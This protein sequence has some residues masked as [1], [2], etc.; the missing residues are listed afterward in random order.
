VGNPTRFQ[1]LA[2]TACFIRVSTPAKLC[3]TTLGQALLGWYCTVENYY[4]FATANDSLLPRTWRTALVSTS[5]TQREAGLSGDKHK[6]AMLNA[7]WKE[8]DDILPDYFEILAGLKSLATLVGKT[9][10]DHLQYVR[11]LTYSTA[12]S[13][14]LPNHPASSKSFKL[15]K[16][17]GWSAP[18][19]LPAVPPPAISASMFPVPASRQ[20]SSQVYRHRIHAHIRHEAHPLIQTQHPARNRVL[21]LRTMSHVPGTRNPVLS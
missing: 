2:G 3:S 12:N 20:F 17:L 7:L 11:D 4:C 14:S 9:A 21:R 13:C 5:E 1:H 15:Q 18:S 10:E 19:T 8:F 16:Y 6:A